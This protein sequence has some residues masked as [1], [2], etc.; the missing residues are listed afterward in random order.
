[1]G[2]STWELNPTTLFS[3][4]HPSV[5]ARSSLAAALAWQPHERHGSERALASSAAFL[6][7][8]EIVIVNWLHGE[9]REYYYLSN[10]S[11]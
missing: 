9:L 7:F 11:I 10:N 2:F 4:T 5:L 6:F 1:M 8:L 3:D